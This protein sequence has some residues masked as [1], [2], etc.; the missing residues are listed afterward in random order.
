LTAQFV[1]HRKGLAKTTQKPYNALTLTDGKQQFVLWLDDD[2]DV[3]DFQ[4]G[5]E[6]KVEVQLY[7]RRDGGAGY[8]VIEVS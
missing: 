6:V 4:E 2:V 3:P 1:S 8:K 5:D 7:G